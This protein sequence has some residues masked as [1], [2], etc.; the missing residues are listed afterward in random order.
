MIDDQAIDIP[1][2]EEAP[3]FHPDVV[4]FI[5]EKRN[6][7]KK[8]YNKPPEENVEYKWDVNKIAEALSISN[9]LV[10]KFCRAKNI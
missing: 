10:A 7:P 2:A 5:L 8:P 3:K 6:L 9:R 4:K 1:P